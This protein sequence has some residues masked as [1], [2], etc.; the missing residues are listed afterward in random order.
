MSSARSLPLLLALAFPACILATPAD[1]GLRAGAGHDA[2]PQPDAAPGAP[3]PVDVPVALLDVAPD[4]ALALDAGSDVPAPQP[5]AAVDAPVPADVPVALADVALAPDAAPDASAPPDVAAPQ[6]DAGPDDAPAQDAPDAHVP[7][8]VPAAVV[9]TPAALDVPATADVLASG[10]VVGLATTDTQELYRDPALPADVIV[11][12][13]DG[14]CA[15]RHPGTRAC[16]GT[17]YDVAQARAGCAT[18]SRSIYLREPGMISRMPGAGGPGV[19]L[20]CWECG[21]A[22]DPME[23]P[24][25]RACL[26]RYGITWVACC[27]P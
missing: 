7:V 18:N 3:V 9:D 20:P 26:P 16:N 12:W 24:F 25:R 4:A 2:A 15:A 13:F 14:A 19:W 1:L 27:A 22:T 8:D 17:Q 6:L 5:D 10:T 21:S 23:V 11:G